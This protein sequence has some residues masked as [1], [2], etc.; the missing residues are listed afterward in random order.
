MDQFDA[1]KR[2]TKN[3]LLPDS[4]KHEAE[5]AMY[6]K[7]MTGRDDTF[8]NNLQEDVYKRQV[9]LQLRW[10]VFIP[11]TGWISMSIWGRN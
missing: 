1:L 10:E 5:N 8:S 2:I 11:T 3:P 6:E 9:L 4:V 7:F